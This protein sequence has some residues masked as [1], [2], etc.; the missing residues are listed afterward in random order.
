MGISMALWD[1]SVL[2][3]PKKTNIMVYKILVGPVLLYVCESWPMSRSD[4][5]LLSL[6]ERRILTYIF[7]P[8]EEN[9]R[10]RKRYNLELYK[11]FIKNQISLVKRTPNVC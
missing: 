3:I 5:R 7:G 10:W 8:V 9:G 4:G 2:L 6:C 1:T 11:L